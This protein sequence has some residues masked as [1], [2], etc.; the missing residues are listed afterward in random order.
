MENTLREVNADRGTIPVVQ[1]GW[2]TLTGDLAI[3]D[4]GYDS[5]SY[6][7]WPP[8]TRRDDRSHQQKEAPQP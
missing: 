6:S 8:S 1:M 4:L 2:G 7:H 3:W 5:A